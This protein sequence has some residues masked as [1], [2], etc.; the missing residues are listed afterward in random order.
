[1]YFKLR[2][3]GPWDLGPFAAVLVPGHTSPGATEYKE[4][5]RDLKELRACA[6]GAN[7]EQ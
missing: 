5:I 1:M 3:A 7:Y 2:Q 6:V 4:T